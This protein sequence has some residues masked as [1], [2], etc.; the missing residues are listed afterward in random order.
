M[1]QPTGQQRNSWLGQAG[2]GLELLDSQVGEPGA[3][4]QH[5]VLWA[6]SETL[7]AS[8]EGQKALGYKL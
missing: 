5:P 4:S 7:G 2:A 6:W 1:V 8:M 3:G